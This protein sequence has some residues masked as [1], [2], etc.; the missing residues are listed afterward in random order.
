MNICDI[1]KLRRIQT[2]AHE[3]VSRQTERQASTGTNLS[4]FGVNTETEFLRMLSGLV[5]KSYTDKI[6]SFR[7][8]ESISLKLPKASIPDMHSLIKL[9]RSLEERYN[10]DDYKK[11]DLRV[12]DYLKF[13]ND[14]VIITALDD[15]LS[16]K[17]AIKD[18]KN[19]RLAPPDFVEGEDSQFAYEPKTDDKD[20]PLFDDLRIEDLVGVARRRLKG[21]T[22][23]TIKNWDVYRVDETTGAIYKAWNAYRCMVAEIQL[24]NE[25]YVLSNGQW[26]QISEDLKQ[27]VHDYFA[28]N[29]V[30]SDCPFLPDNVPIYDVE[31]E[32]FREEVFN[33]HVA[34]VDADTYLFDKSKV[35]IAGKKIYEICD[36]FRKD[37]AMIHVKRHSSGSAS[38]N[39]VF[40]QAKLYAHAFSAEAVT[41]QGMRD[42]VD[43][44]QE[45][46][47]IGKVKDE[48]KNKIPENDTDVDEKRHKVIFCILTGADAMDLAGLPFMTQ[49]ELMLA[50]RYLTHD[51]KFQASMTFKKVDLAKP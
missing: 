10:S 11:T 27:K 13:M 3:A 37:G 19:V 4:V 8:K 35:E 2:T 45:P 30:I 46:E 12:Y 17:I 40:T 43:N 29:N 42:W 31:R 25:T 20:P 34:K 32:Q 23:S 26:R 7:G 21:L 49:Y 22:A 9:C 47:N 51:R 6:E 39:H 41:R 14:P 36:L 1:D 28:A 24:N 16:A 33:R 15:Q 5:A 18:F 38:V 48:F 44:N 50:H